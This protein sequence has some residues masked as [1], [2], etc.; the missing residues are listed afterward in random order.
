MELQLP[1]PPQNPTNIVYNTEGYYP[2]T[3]TG[4]NQN[5]SVTVTK[6]DYIHV[7]Y[8]CSYDSNIDDNDGVAYYRA[9]TGS[10][11][12]LPGYTNTTVTAFADKFTIGNLTGKVKSMAVAVALAD[13]VGGTT[14]VTFTIWDNNAGIPGAVLMT[15][16]VLVKDLEAGVINYI[17]FTPTAVG[18]T[19]FAGFQLPT[20]A[21]LDT[22]AC[23]FAT[24]APNR[25]NTAYCLDGTTW[26]TYEAKY[27]KNGSLYILP[28]FC[29]D[30][31]ITSVPDVDF[32]AS[33]TEITPGTTISFTDQ[34]TGG[35][36]PTSWSW[37][38]TGGS[39]VSSTVQNPP[40]VTYSTAGIYD[41][42]LSATNA[43]GAGSRTKGGY[44]LVSDQSNV[45]YWNF[46]NTVD[47]AT[48]DGGATA[49]LS[50]TI[51]ISGT[52]TGLV[53]SN[54]GATTRCAGSTGWNDSVAAYNDYWY[55]EFSTVGFINVKMSS[56][57]SG[58]T[59]AAPKNFAVY[60]SADGGENFSFLTNVP[61]M[62]T[63]NNW[64][65]GVLSNVALPSECDNQESVML[66]WLKT[67]DIA[68][69]GATQTTTNTYGNAVSLIDDIYVTGQTCSAVP[70]A[71]GT[72]TGP[73]TICQ[74]ATAT[75]TVPAIARAT[76]Y[77]WTVPTGVTIIN[78]N[79][80]NTITVQLA[81]DA[82][83]GSITVYGENLC[84]VG[85]VSAAKS[86]TV[87][88][89]PT[90]PTT[91]TGSQSIT[92]GQTG[93][94]YSIPAISGATSYVWTVPSFCT[95]TAGSTTNA[96]T[97]SFACPGGSENMMVH[98]VN[99][100]GAGPDS[101]AKT[102]TI[103]CPPAS[104][105]YASTTQVCS[106]GTV[107]FTDISTNHP[108]SW[109]WSFPGGTPS[110]STL[111]HPTVTYSTLGTYAVTLTATNANGSDAETKTAYIN[112]GVPA[113]PSAITGSSTPCAGATQTYSVTNVDDVTYTWTVP[114]GWTILSGAGTNSISVTVGT[115]SGTIQV[116]PSNT[117]GNGTA[118]TMTATIGTAVAAS[119][120]IAASANPACIGSSVVFTATPTNG[121]TTPAYQWLVGTTSVGTGSTY[122]SAA[123]ANGNIVTCVMTSN[124][125]CV[126]GS[127]ATSNAVTMTI[128]PASVGGTVTGG[129]TI[130]SGSTSGLLT[131]AGHTGT[132]VRWQSSID[133]GANWT[134]ITNTA[135]TYTSGALT[136]T[137]LFRAVV[138]SGSCS[139]A[140]SSST[141]VT[142]S[143]A[144]V[145]G[146]VSG[147]TT[148]CTGSTSGLLTLAG[149]TGTVVRWQSS[150]DGGANWTNITNTAT[151]YTSG[152]LT[153]T[154][155]FRAVVQSG[156]C[157]T[158]NSSSTMV[159]V[160]PASVGGTV[161]GG[162]TICTG[163]TSGV[164]TLAGNT[165]TVVRWES[166]VS[167]FT[168]WTSIANTASTYTSGAL[169]ATTQFRAVVQ[170]GSCSTANSASTTV[171]VSPASVGGTVSGG[172][173]ICT[174]STSGVLTLAGNTGTV[175]RWESSVSPFTT[176]TSIA[177]TS[178]TYTSGALT[179]TTQFRAVVQSGSCSTAN[180]A[181]T[182]VTVSPASVGGTVSGG[183][184]I[185][186]GSTSGVLT[187]AGNTGTVV[188]WE[189][190]V[191]PF[192][193][194]TSIANTAS[195][196]TSGVLTATT[197]FRAVVQSGSCSTANSVSTTV[198]VSPA[199]VG[200]TVSGG[201]TICT[202]STS[203]VL[204]LAG[205]TGTVVRW[206]SSV[207][208]FTT[209]TSI[210]N[211]ASTYTS[212]AL[213]ATTQFRAVVQSGSCST[214]NSASTTVTVDPVSVGGTLATGITS[215]YLGQTTGTITL[216]ANVGT[217]V[218]WQKS[219]DGGSNWTDISNTAL[220][221]SETPNA[222]GTWLYRAVVQ[223]GACS[224]AYSATVS[225]Q[226][227]ASSSGAV[228]GG[229]SPICLGTATGTMTLGNYTGTIV[230]WQK[231]SDGGTIWTDIANTTTTYSETPLT[232]GTWL[233]R[234]VVNNGSDLYSAPATI[235]VN[236]V[237]VGGTVSGGTTI[238]TGSTSGVLTLAGNT[239]TVVRW[240]SSV[241]PFTTWTSIANTASTYTSGA[242]TA[243]TQFRAVVQSGSCSTANSAPTTVTVS[244][245]TVGGAVT[246]DATICTG[247]AS[248][249][250]ALSGNT[251]SVIRWESSVSPFT[252][253]TTIANTTATY[254]SGALTATTQFRAVVQSG[255]CSVAN[256]TPATITVSPATVG[257][258][259]TAGVTSIFFGQSTGTITLAGQT[260]TIVKWQKRLGTTAWT[261][262][263]NTTTT[264]SENP[265]AVGFWEYRAVVRSG[266]CTEANSASVIIEVVA[267][268]SGA[269]S[270]GTTPICFGT[271]TGTL[272]LSGYTG[273]IVKW[274]KRVDSGSWIDLTNTATTY[275]ETPTSAGTWE[276]RAV[277]NNGSDSYSGSVTIVVNPTTVPGSVSGG[278]T[279][280]AGNTS[281]VLTLSG[282]T[283]TVVKW[284]SAVSPFTTWTDIANTVSTYTSGVLT[285]TTQFRA[286]VQSGS[287]SD[288]NSTATT[289]TVDPV[290]VGGSVT[291]GTTICSGTASGVLTLSGYTGAIVR[292][293]S[294]ISPFTIWTP[295]INTAT[296]YT[297]SSVSQA[298]QFRAVVQ[299]GSCSEVYS[300]ATTVDVYPGAA[301]GSVT[302][303]SH[304]CMGS[305]SD[306][307]TLSGHSGTIVRWESSV[308]PFT[309]WTTIN[310]TAT[311]Y[312][313]GS[314]SETT[315]FRVALQNGTCPNVYSTPATVTVDPAS[316]GGSVSGD[317]TICAGNTSGTLTLSGNTGT[318]VKWQSAVNPF[319]V[320]VDIANTAN[321]YVSGALTEAT[322]FRAVVQS[323]VCAQAI[324]SATTISVDAMPTDSFTYVATGLSVAF[325][326]A[327]VGAASYLWDFGSGTSTST[328][329]NP[330]F[331]Y[332]SDGTYTV[333]LT[334]TNGTCTATSTKQI[335]VVG[336]GIGE[337]N[338]LSMNI[339]PIPTTGKVNIQFGAQSI[340]NAQLSVVDI[341]GKII[342]A[343]VISNIYSN[344]LMVLDLT[345]LV[346][347]V[348]NIRIKNDTQVINKVVIIER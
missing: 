33:Q 338:S 178:S 243:T 163:S 337:S 94:A 202:G 1:Q 292:W 287:C 148:I 211:T 303:G 191:S 271:P 247:S 189:S 101:Y 293:E 60:Y 76:Y 318:V 118:Q 31:P 237:S 72:I 327:S 281:A 324:S 203:G 53:Y 139:T 125:N 12:Y 102:I 14:N 174:G 218:K 270:G 212:G 220:T 18:S 88:L 313:S 112:V 239:G 180:S 98:A 184:T 222:V 74:G 283:G 136:Q 4:T 345:N 129:T 265:S 240:E 257:G 266:S 346:P 66:L 5:G 46:P 143:P 335:T 6:T 319:N 97:T 344:Q 312:T 44:I 316:I 173:T 159:T 205:N 290:S 30:K 298:T 52:L 161:S 286:V 261:D 182:T 275:V 147:G 185:C 333:V 341:T 89:L 50:K 135:T 96:I 68:M 311:T 282:N 151:T 242:L 104:N 145:G 140:N 224:V 84:G 332:P 223:S 213:T 228:T 295:I 177:N 90:A 308:S 197:Q 36:T 269:V 81:D 301:G 244:P 249:A 186:T 307:L 259:V 26:T 106:G 16:N 86:F 17:D 264:Y 154:T 9:P 248:G 114:S 340:D 32:F 300:A 309:T 83:N 78:G 8:G 144:S 291:G 329:A 41:V 100:C 246:S 157:S 183:T 226:V 179:A 343:K 215:I 296:T 132:I 47:N 67:T 99:A 201:T 39:P 170:S 331:V 342:Y 276:Y 258:S 245:V 153:Q 208:P 7:F 15:K 128:N 277:V 209:W 241:P 64:T 42:S 251:G 285:A 11:G 85:T 169:T 306:V 162:T 260:G 3:L 348:Y 65:Q 236:P 347:G 70:A 320:W 238:C 204:T 167:P 77:N 176:W 133:G 120:S 198:T 49:N 168:T 255:S 54:T 216:S 146:T 297:A 164:L 2:V 323:G 195:T 110:T 192:T 217:V 199:S 272:T 122:T 87:T 233:Y 200:G 152:A 310:N 221:Y 336:D 279:I 134:N 130:C 82:T 304:V 37:T 325:H 103:P 305:T 232:A 175:V 51:G 13:V 165:G 71:A 314:L 207:S 158:A 288:D 79:Y 20:V 121:G 328:L 111:E 93:V 25:I 156:S 117:C 59:T 190:S 22:F 268:N 107:T 149:H 95:I 138:Q 150:I 214:A 250:L 160:S 62:S 126:T 55:V 23:Y 172:T 187:L 115:T 181:S 56:K 273:T 317:T 40:S 29:F 108:T 231:S 280:C 194:W 229:N 61:A 142:V 57:Q 254:I 330:T 235:I 284:Q 339:F 119:V 234:G 227:L 80:T 262:I 334:V 28:E 34:S 274:Q 141:M 45:V 19:F 105:F 188:R 92:N 210:A 278:T 73:S 322:Q 48:A 109:S 230:K 253:W 91:I 225:V 193:T 27:G 43:N 10:V 315:Q 69:S 35:P 63:A 321:T 127:P 263:T 302:G 267:T 38:L 124:A 289:V 171:T 116:T 131:L 299:S 294:S 326:N 113:Q 256:S 21:S 137:T 206:E 75:F 155:L 24:G 219:N 252:T 58:K 166:S 196:Y 123:L